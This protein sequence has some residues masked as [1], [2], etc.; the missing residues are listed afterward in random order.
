MSPAD[1]DI[2]GAPVVIG[3]GVAG[4]MTALRMAQPVVLLSSTRD[5]RFATHSAAAALSWM[6]PDTE[7]MV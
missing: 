5:C 6:S 2:G 3:A 1:H 7:H 4:L